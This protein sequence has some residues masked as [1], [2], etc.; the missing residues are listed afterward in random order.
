MPL[1]TRSQPSSFTAPRQGLDGA[2]KIASCWD[3]H[4]CS[5]GTLSKL[6]RQQYRVT[7]SLGGGGTGGLI[8]PFFGRTPIIDY[9]KL[10]HAPD[11]SRHASQNEH[12]VRYPR[13]IL[14]RSGRLPGELKNAEAMAAVKAPARV[15]LL[16]Q[17]LLHLVGDSTAG[18]NGELSTELA[19]YDR[20]RRPC[21]P[22]NLDK[23][24]LSD[25]AA[26]REQLDRRHT[27]PP[28]GRRC[29]SVRQPATS[30]QMSPRT[31]DSGQVR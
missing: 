14:C 11:P 7:P 15:G 17:S 30:Q 13:L 21:G 6:I 31:V 12:E 29:S 8:L 28:S 4:S 10:I 2:D 1:A 24:P 22:I 18:D 20:R 26:R 9:E 3:L 16:H 27:M 25:Q 23:A 19:A 5:L